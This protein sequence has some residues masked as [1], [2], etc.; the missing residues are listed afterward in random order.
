MMA[1]SSAHTGQRAKRT[2]K[3]GRAF[4]IESLVMFVFLVAT[5]AIV[6]QLFIASANKSVQ[7]QDLER[8]SLLAAN[9]AERFSADPLSNNLNLSQDGL[10]VTCAVTPQPLSSGTLYKAVITVS[11]GYDDIYT[12][13]T[14]RYVSVVI[15]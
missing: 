13:E 14:A 1:M 9:V 15:R 12:I 3:S 11:D 8:S 10:F 6:T 7:G 4:I 5:L 2:R